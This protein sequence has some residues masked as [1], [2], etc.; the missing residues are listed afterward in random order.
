MGPP[1]RFPRVLVADGVN[2]FRLNACGPLVFT[3]LG[4]SRQCGAL[5]EVGDD[6]LGKQGISRAVAHC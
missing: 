1:G 3:P 5:V 2:P 6:V 4:A